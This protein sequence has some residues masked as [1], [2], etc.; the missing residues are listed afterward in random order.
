MPAILSKNV[1]TLL[2]RVV[3]GVSLI[4][5]LIAL[6]A[7]L[8]LGTFTRYISDDYCEAIRVNRTSPVTAVIE[9]YIGGQWR[10]A[11]RFSNLLF[12]GLSETLGPSNVPIAAVSMILLWIF[13]LIWSLYGVQ[14]L[15]SLQWSFVLTSFLA[16]LLAFFTILQ[17]PDLFQTLYWR[18]GMATHFAPL[19]F[20]FLLAGFV[21]YYIRHSH[22]GSPTIWVTV[23]VF[24]AA[25]MIGGFSE[26]PT[27]MMI[28]ALG[29][30]LAGLW[31]WG[32]GSSR[33]PA[34][35]LS[36]ATLVGALLAMAVMFFSPANT[37]HS[38][39]ASSPNFPAVVV[40]T[41]RYTFEFMADT[42]HI[43][44]LPSLISAL[45][46]AP[47]LFC[48]HCGQYSLPLNAT[49]RRHLLILLVLIPLIL[50]VLVAA[51]FAPSAYG[52]S[53]PEARARFL[54]RLLMTA[55]LMLEG[56]ILGVLAAQSRGVP[57]WRSWIFPFA[58]LGI[59]IFALYPIRAAWITVTVD[60]VK[61]RTWTNAWDAR[62]AQILTEKSQGSRDLVV[63]HI[64]GFEYLKEFDVRAKNRI[65]RCAA[66]FYGVR[67][68]RTV[69][70]GP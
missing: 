45:L 41:V 68:I 28:L 43:L 18:S 8:Y 20:Q 47:V 29:F 34:L 64:S 61:Y 32:R 51:S 23:L 44:P 40:R 24:L 21:L 66:T 19:V 42:L 3:I 59:F 39:V 35:I 11:D 9:R 57:D 56:G 60:S 7:F 58:C 36:A 54:G 65:N 13:S 50:F 55:A 31:L 26:P 67:S 30:I 17:A 14:K 16:A 70:A 2:F 10:A 12:V 38:E 48:Q 25:F 33:R 52:Q 49:Q 1:E 27:A 15:A 63:Q 69:R 46:P 22:G 5:T 4:A 53:Y 62:N 37:L 6:G